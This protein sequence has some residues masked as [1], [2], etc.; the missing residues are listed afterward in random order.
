MSFQYFY[1]FINISALVG[2][3]ATTYAETVT[4]PPQCFRLLQRNI[5]Y[6]GFATFT[7]PAIVFLLCLIILY[8]GRN[9][10]ARSP[11]PSSVLTS[12]DS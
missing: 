2:Q 4:H 5:Q 9:C 10:Y 6:V 12:S 11:F 8:L 1:L 3:I 7:L